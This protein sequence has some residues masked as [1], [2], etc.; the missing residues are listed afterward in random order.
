MSAALAVCRL[1]PFAPRKKGCFRGAK[2]DDAPHSFYEVGRTGSSCIRSLG[3]RAR[4]S[5]FLATLSSP[6]PKAFPLPMPSSS[7]SRNRSPAVTASTPSKRAER[8]AA[9]RRRTSEVHVAGLHGSQPGVGAEAELLARAA[10]QASNS[11]AGTATRGP[12]PGWPSGRRA[13]RRVGIGDQAKPQPL[14][15]GKD[16][17][18]SFTAT[19][20]ARRKAALWKA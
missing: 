10:S 6:N 3:R 9:P 11:L 16:G 18:N 20:A 4:R 19:G 7:A 5:P 13:S 2:G 15:G 17:S 1:S 8:S 14:P 12:S